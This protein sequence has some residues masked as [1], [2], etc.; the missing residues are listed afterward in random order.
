[1]KK[2]GIIA[3]LSCVV[4]LC[5]ALVGCGGE[6]P[7]DEATVAK[8]AFA[9]SWEL[10]SMSQ[11]G[12]TT[13]S[14]DVQMLAALG[15]KVTLSLNEDGSAKLVVFD[16]TMTGTWEA[17]DATT[18]TAVLDGQSVDMTLDGEQLTLAE[19]G[20]T[21][22]FKKGAAASSASAASTDAEAS[23]ET[24]SS[25]TASGEAAE[26]EGASSESAA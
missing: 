20:S 3:V 15:M 9:G 8:E 4:A 17:A 18:A 11:N 22:T 1:M 13:T 10:T 7:V 2:L 6:P 19:S 24:E 14:D 25:E 12:D 23:D 16:S 26:T 5:A 21:M